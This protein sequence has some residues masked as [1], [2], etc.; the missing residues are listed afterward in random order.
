MCCI[1][2][3][4]AYIVV[5]A[6]IR[7]EGDKYQFAANRNFN[8]KGNTLSGNQYLRHIKTRHL[9]IE[10]ILGNFLRRL[11]SKEIRNNNKNIFFNKQNH[12]EVMLYFYDVW[13]IYH[14]YI[15]PRII[16]RVKFFFL[17][18]FLFNYNLKNNYYGDASCVVSF[19]FTLTQALA[20]CETPFAVTLTQRTAL[21]ITSF[22]SPSL[23]HLHLG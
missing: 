22:A 23:W 21:C 19:V 11:I 6:K 17:Y 3:V 14:T 7:S 4:D 2:V 20:F 15:P 12:C 8:Y 10:K 18:D 5:R 16:G 9:S 13:V 1:Y